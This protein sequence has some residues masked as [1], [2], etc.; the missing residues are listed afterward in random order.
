[1]KTIVYIGGF[2]PPDRNAAAQRVLNNARVLHALGHRALLDRL[3]G[4]V[5]LLG[6]RPRSEV[7]RSRPSPS[8]CATKAA[9]RSRASRR[10]IR[11]WGPFG[12]PCIINALSSVRAHHVEGR[13]GFTI[14]PDDRD[15]AARRLCDMLAMD[16]EAIMAMKRYCHQCGAFTAEGFE[17]PVAD[18]LSAV[19]GEERA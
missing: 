19:N 18:F 5:E 2:E 13:T 9:S 12:T 14:D 6:R 11:K 4:R 1:M 15:D 7:L 10:N 8:C 16:S 17:A 3:G